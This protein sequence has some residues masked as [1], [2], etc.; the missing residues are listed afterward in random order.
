MRN[1]YIDEAGTSAP[2]PVSVVA[3]LIVNPDIHWYPVMRRVRE[4]WDHH[5][6]SEYRHENR[7][8]LHKDFTFHA[9]SVSDASKYLRWSEAS[10]RALLLA[11]MAIPGEFNIPITFGAVKR[12]ALDWS[13]WP[14]HRKKQMTPAKS[15]HMSAFMG[16]IGEAN[17]F[18][19][20]EYPSELAQVISDRHSEMPQIL[21][22]TLND[23]QARPFPMET[24]VSR[25]GREP[26]IRTE[27]LGADRIIDEVYFLEHRNAPF[28]QIVDAVAFGLRRY[29]A[30]Q[31]SG[32]DCLHAISDAR[33]LKMPADWR[34]FFCAI[35]HKDKLI[36]TPPPN[37][38]IVIEHGMPVVPHNRSCPGRAEEFGRQ[39][40]RRTASQTQNS[41]LIAC[42]TDFSFTKDKPAMRS[43]S[44]SSGAPAPCEARCD[45]LTRRDM[46]RRWSS[47]APL[48]INCM[49]WNTPAL[50]PSRVTCAAMP[51]TT[52]SFN[53][54]SPA[55]LGGY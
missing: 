52:R 35:S 22:T 29:L 33:A 45:F 13:G 1:I 9:K 18:I 8:K 41:D 40:L 34:M 3:A 16:C 17:K 6:P 55:S 48:A 31:S 4:I 5:I 47:S 19:R 39:N 26:E 36:V 54:S 38:I 20:T 25:E 44:I 7:H 32:E 10:R 23:M 2:E 43:R 11:M 12:S 14:E 27:M 30:G 51:R 24:Y 49:Q 42:Q 46:R 37:R 28:L 50:S 53:L 15:D 21:R